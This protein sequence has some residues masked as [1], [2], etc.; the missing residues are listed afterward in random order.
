MKIGIVTIIDY[1][2]YGNQLQN[3]A[4]H[5]LLHNLY[6]CE[7]ITINAT[8]EKNFCN[9]KYIAWF[10]EQLARKLC[11]FPKIA[12]K[13]FGSN[14]TRWNNFIKW[15]KKIPKKTYYN[16]KHLST[17]VADQFDVF[18]AGSDQIWNYHFSSE[19]FY[20]YFLK[21]A[22]EEQRIAISA[23]FGVEVIPEEWKEQYI[24]G[25]SHFKNISVREEAGKKLIKEL[26]GADVPVLVDPTMMLSTTEWLNVAEKPRV[27]ISKQ[28]VLKYYLGDEEDSSI[29]NWAK[30]NGFEVYELLNGDIPELYSAG[31]GEFITLINNASLVCSDS[32]H[33]IVFA[34]LFSK[35]FIVYQRQ[36]KE[37][38]MTSRLDT[39]LKKFNFQN[40]WNHILNYDDYLKCDYSQT[41]GL[42]EKE[43]EK[44]INFLSNALGE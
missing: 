10:K 12:E 41:R 43:Q 6:D 23:S 24:E 14:I 3:Y 8:N 29:D 35:P 39:L 17:K 9:G 25:L 31:P 21:F 22:C 18:F 27:D 15:S 2:N 28:Y 36:G 20:D 33:C 32:F 34:I 19:Q 4:V 16:S 37:D 26:V 5:K 13:R 11:I 40:R 42:L 30:K 1:T 7:I 44:F 38:Y